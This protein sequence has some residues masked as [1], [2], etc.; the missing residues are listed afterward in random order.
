MTQQAGIGSQKTAPGNRNQRVATEREGLRLWIGRA[1][2]VLSRK[3]RDRRSAIAAPLASVGGLGNPGRR[4]LGP[5]V[6]APPTGRFRTATAFP[7]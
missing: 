1:F 6:P 2:W 3:L 4:R 7:S 5:A